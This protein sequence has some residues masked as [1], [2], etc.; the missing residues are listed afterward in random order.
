LPAG[1]GSPDFVF[2]LIAFVAYRFDLLR[3]M[4][5]SF[6]FGWMMD[7]VSGIYLGTYLLEYLLFFTVLNALTGNSPLKESAYQVPLVGLFYFIVQILLYFTLTMMI[8][9]E[10]PPWSWSRIVRETII[11]TVA[12]IPCFLLFNSFNEYLVKRKAFRRSSRRG[13]GNQYR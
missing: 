10:L 3:G 13:N 8:S 7:V 6:V 12:T 1:L 4:F 2:I 5:L 11:L 9:D